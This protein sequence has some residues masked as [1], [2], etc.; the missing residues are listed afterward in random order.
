MRFFRAAELPLRRRD[1][2]SGNGLATVGG[3]GS[4]VSGSID[5]VRA[6]KPSFG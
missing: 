3:G 6:G 5:L 2:G 4:R 1:G